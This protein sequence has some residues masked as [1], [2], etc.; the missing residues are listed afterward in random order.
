[1]RRARGMTLLEV[2]VAVVVC[3]AGIAVVAGGV[4][5]A[6]RGEAYA[7]DRVRA[8]DQLDLLLARLESGE[9]ALEAA[10]GEL[11]DAGPPALRWEVEVASGDLEGLTVATATV[12]W[13][14][15]GVERR[16][17]VARSFFV[18]PLTGTR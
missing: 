18:D 10:E 15:H 6:V 7:G 3:G 12:L 13:E 16:L 17:A 4:S 11:P 1:V 5:A 8:A 14:R 2:L 9:L